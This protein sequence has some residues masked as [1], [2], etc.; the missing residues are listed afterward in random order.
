ME[1]PITLQES[2][3]PS[4]PTSVQDE[5]EDL[6][7]VLAGDDDSKDAVAV[8]VSLVE[9]DLEDDVEGDV[10][11]MDEPADEVAHDDALAALAERVE[12]LSDALEAERAERERLAGQLDVLATEFDALLGE[13]LDR[14]RQRRELLE[15]TLR[16]V[17]ATLA[18]AGRPAWEGDD[19]RA[20][21]D[22]RTASERRRGLPERPL[23]ARRA[24][25][26]P[27]VP[28]EVAAV[29]DAPADDLEVAADDE[30]FDSQDDERP[31]VWK[32]RLHDVAG[33][34]SAWSSED[35]DRLR[36]E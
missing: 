23:R 30:T 28:V 4:E 20:G 33:S 16:E 35:I 34:V 11:E 19:R 5:W 26:E 29:P 9:D 25:D 7:Q 27:I 31:S 12:Q 18:D 32:G 17:Q 2:E 3:A 14:E 6:R 1:A 8:D 15:T 13:A 21:I 22:R 36:V 24:S 10:E